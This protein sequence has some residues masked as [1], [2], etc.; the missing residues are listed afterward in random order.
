[1]NQRRVTLL[2]SLFLLFSAGKFYGDEIRGKVI[3]TVAPLWGG[4]SHLTHGTSDYPAVEAK[5]IYRSP[6]LWRSSLWIDQGE[7]R[8]AL[9]SPVIKGSSLVGVVDYVGKKQSRVRLITDS[10]LSPSVRVSRGADQY[11]KLVED[12][13][14]LLLDLKWFSKEEH[15]GLNEKAI[16]LLSELKRTY[17]AGEERHLLAKGEIRGS[18]QPLWKRGGQLLKGVGFNLDAGDEKSPA[19]DLRSGEPLSENNKERVPI[20]AQHDLLVTSG[21]DGIFPAGLFVAVVTKIDLLQEGD[22]FYKLEARPTVGNL[23]EITT[24]EVLPPLGYDALD[25]PPTWRR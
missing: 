13:D 9:N 2:S 7:G 14:Q 16:E 22:F 18:S 1:M 15:D 11:R 3:A 25:L 12:A 23:D 17:G 4:I 5:V 24:L 6:S 20:I 10:G 8:V 21:L 19:R